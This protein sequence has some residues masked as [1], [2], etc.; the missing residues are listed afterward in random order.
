MPNLFT[1]T[2]KNVVQKVERKS[3]W[4]EVTAFIPKCRENT[5]GEER[6]YLENRWGEKESVEGVRAKYVDR[7]AEPFMRS[8]FMHIACTNGAQLWYRRLWLPKSLHIRSL[9]NRKDELQLSIQLYM[10]YTVNSD[11][12]TPVFM[13]KEKLNSFNKKLMNSYSH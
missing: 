8:S 10:N 2:I 6:I 9:K 7:I 12:V 4:A 5:E 3:L 11:K 13:S 1:I